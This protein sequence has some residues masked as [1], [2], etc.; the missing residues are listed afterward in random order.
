MKKNVVILANGLFPEHDIPAG[1][2]RNAA[3]II[4]C[5]GA[6]AKLVEKGMEPW[7]VVGDLD[8][9]PD[10][11]AERF[12]DRLYRDD[13]QESNDLTKAVK[14]AVGRGYE[15]IVILGATGL[16]EDH[17]A[18][19]ISLLTDYAGFAEVIMVTDHGIFVPVRSGTTISS[20]PGQQ[21]SVF[22]ASHDIKIT[23]TGLKYRLENMK[24]LNWWTGT[25]N[26]S[27]GDNFSVVFEGG[28]FILLFLAF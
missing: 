12:A 14:F 3:H 19:N 26:E 21:V 4:C 8:S 5:D 28:E 16:R 11:L 24:L 1:Y 22:S 18:G 9:V 7:A 10:E 25:L 27:V 2:L 15:S 17:T 6:V 13:D 23:S 20:W